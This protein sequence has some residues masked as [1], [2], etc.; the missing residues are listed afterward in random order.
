[1]ANLIAAL[2]RHG[3]YHQLQDTPSAHQPFPLNEAGERQAADA[4]DE[5]CTLIERNDWEL[6][7]V[8]DSSRMLRAWQT[9]GIF[10]YRLAG[11][12]DQDIRVESLDELAERGHKIEASGAWTGGNTLAASIDP[13]TNLLCAAASPRLDPAYAAGF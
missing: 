4:A 3:E 6:V 1:M 5:L 11:T 9:A 10:A 12:S 8:I 7:P 2:V 13:E